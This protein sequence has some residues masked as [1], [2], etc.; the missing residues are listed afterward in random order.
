MGYK[1]PNEVNICIKTLEDAG[2]E[3]WCVG[4]SV[5]DFI[6]GKTPSDYDI[7]TNALPNDIVKH[8]PHTIPTGIKHGT[9]TV[10]INR[11]PIEVTTYRADG[12]YHNNRTPDNVSFLESIDGD[13]LRRDFTVNA[14]CYNPKKGVYDPLLGESDINAK[15]IRAIGNPEE[16]FLEDALRIMRAFR[17]SA[18]LGFE[19]EDKTAKKA[20]ELSHLLQNISVERI[21]IEL[22]KTF[23]SE[24]PEKL[25]PLINCGA[26]S[27]L[28]FDKCIFP[29]NLKNSSANF[30]LRFAIFC[31]ENNLMSDKILTLLKSDNNARKTVATFEKMLKLNVA[32]KT[33]IKKLL[34][35]GGKEIT[36]EFLQYIDGKTGSNFVELLHDILLHNEAYSI[37][38]LALNGNDIK[39]A[40]F[41]DK[42]IGSILQKLL[43]FV[44]ENPQSN[45][46]DILK[47]Q[48][49]LLK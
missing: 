17:F 9:V 10:L 30:N 48:L 25:L 45:T 24:N 40:G 11:M 5:R 43:L 21:Y 44:L 31:N 36:E 12:Q 18:Q 27:F 22:K 8:F 16:R 7:T 38:M 34:Y 4:G 19:I 15:I 6:M 35:I 14:I 2:F 3:A 49:S 47:R 32:N 1:L 23:V 42:E 46:P 29:Q 39:Q 20:L 37:N 26:L 28:G 33:D 13:L 41:A